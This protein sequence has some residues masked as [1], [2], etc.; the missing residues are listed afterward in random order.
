MSDVT[1]VLSDIIRVLS[2]VEG[3]QN[4][5]TCTL[6]KNRILILVLLYMILIDQG[7]GP[8]GQRQPIA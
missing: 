1:R 8:A 3:P 4:L 2:N 7:M 6:Q 5:G